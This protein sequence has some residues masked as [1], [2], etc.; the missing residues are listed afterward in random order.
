MAIVYGVTFAKLPTGELVIVLSINSRKRRVTVGTRRL[1][2]GIGS[3]Y[4]SIL[5][6]ADSLVFRCGTVTGD[7]SGNTGQDDG[8]GGT[9]K[10]NYCYWYGSWGCEDDDWQS[11]DE[12]F[13]SIGE[14]YDAECTKH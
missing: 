4:A 5:M 3:K 8:K 7:G 1:N 2:K 14:L 11:Y 9:Q 13:S 12:Y 6:F 10:E